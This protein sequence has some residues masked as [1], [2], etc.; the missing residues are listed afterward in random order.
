MTKNLGTHEALELHEYLVFKNI[1]LTKSATMSKLVQDGELKTILEQD[2][3][4]GVRHIETL[5]QF[6]ANRGM[7]Q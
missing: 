2:A 7:Q 1:T 3:E 4:M 6:I 5:Q